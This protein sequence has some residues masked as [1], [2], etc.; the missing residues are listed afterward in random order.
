M[1]LEG[2]QLLGPVE[3]PSP[4][5]S[6]QDCA[7]RDTPFEATG[8]CDA[9]SAP[10]DRSFETGCDLESEL[11]TGAGPE[12]VMVQHP[13]DMVLPSACNRCCVVTPLSTFTVIVSP[14]HVQ[15]PPGVHIGQVTCVLPL[16]RIKEG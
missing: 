12:R 4:V 3:P 14:E 7:C 5:M 16:G 13:P 9:E 15:L 10:G 1:P 11:I 8:V 6:L 2:L